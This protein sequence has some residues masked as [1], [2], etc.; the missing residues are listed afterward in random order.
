MIIQEV[1][2]YKYP[3]AS[4][5]YLRYQMTRDAKKKM[6]E[7]GEYENTPSTSMKSNGN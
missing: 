5:S 7:A 3:K 4:I 2:L 1:K 6:N